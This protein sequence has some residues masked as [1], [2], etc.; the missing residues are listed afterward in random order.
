M[1]AGK[2]AIR[3]RFRCIAIGDPHV[4]PDAPG[5]FTAAVSDLAKLEPDLVLVMGDLSGGRWTGTSKGVRAAVDALN[6]L[7]CPW[8]TA[9]GNHDLQATDEFDTDEANLAGFLAAV[10]R[11]SPWASL[12]SNGIF[13]AVLGN[14]AWR[15][16][17][18]QPHEVRIFEDQLEWLRGELRNRPSTPTV[19]ATHAPMLGS[20]LRILPSV[21]GIAG[22]AYINHC[23]HPAALAE[24]WTENPQI[25][26]WL[27]GHSHLG[28]DYPDA[29]SERRGTLFVHV[30]VPTAAASRDGCRHSRAI[31]F[32]DRDVKVRTYDHTAGRLREKPDWTAGV[33]AEK[34]VARTAVFLP[35]AVRDGAAPGLSISEDGRSV[36]VAD[37]P[38]V[39][40]L[41]W[42]DAPVSALAWAAD[43]RLLVGTEGGAVWEYAPRAEAPSGVLLEAPAPIQC[44][45]AEPNGSALWA[46]D[47]SGAVARLDISDPDRF[48]HSPNVR[49]RKPVFW[50]LPF[51][52]CRFRFAKGRTGVF[53]EARDGR[54]CRI[55]PASGAPSGITSREASSADAGRSGGKPVAHPVTPESE[56]T[57][58]I[59]PGTITIAEDGRS[60]RCVLE[61]GGR[62]VEVRRIMRRAARI[63]AHA[64]LENMIA[65][66]PYIPRARDYPVLV[67]EA[68]AAP[69]KVRLALEGEVVGSAAGGRRTVRGTVEIRR[70]DPPISVVRFP[71]ANGE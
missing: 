50:I 38:I 10:G 62:R 34:M 37:L 8:L 9:V 29:I 57:V 27:S 1:A 19:I 33:P 44:L 70:G 30:G 35:S 22:N 20:G 61:A 55:A 5:D 51:P 18:P 66:A 15:G 16:N 56:T 2:A 31:D 65:L 14:Q 48:I 67:L 23:H 32:E 13:F 36:E 46:A 3:K 59:Q 63:T 12:E 26:I 25:I 58:D 68:R 42:H 53:A 17:V 39:N 40:F 6:R 43:G 60:L 7:P 54:A 49:P 45:A 4:D 24:I 52:V 69:A 47:V 71:E 21:H 41:P 11:V 64:A 28:H